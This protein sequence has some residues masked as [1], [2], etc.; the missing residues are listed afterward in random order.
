M[1]GAGSGGRALAALLIG[2]VMAGGVPA[3]AAAP[4][5]S[6]PEA[7]ST[8]SAPGVMAPTLSFTK[9]G[10]ISPAGI[11]L[12]VTWPRATQDGAPIA[13]YELERSLDGDAWT[14]VSLPKPKARSVAVKVRPWAVVRFRVRAVDTANEVGLWVES[15]PRWVS[16]AQEDDPAVALE[17]SWQS[18]ARNRAYGGR[19]ATSTYA[20]DTARYSFVGRQVA[21]VAGL[22]PNLGQAAVSA[23]GGSATSVD[24]YRSKASSRRIVYRQTWPEDGAHTLE[25]T[26][27]SPGAAVDVDAFLVLGDPGDATLVGAGDI[28]WC[29]SNGDSK[30]AAVIAGIEGIVYTAGDNAYPSGTPEEF[31]TC[32]DPTWGAF[33]DRTR[34][35]PGNHDYD[36]PGGAGYFEYFGANAGKPGE[37]WYWYEAGTWRVYALNSECADIGGCDVGSAQY[38]WL[39]ANL[40]AE[41]HRCVLSYWHYPLY[42][43]GQHGGSARM[44]AIF[45][46]L[47]NAGADLVL[48]AHDHTYERFAKARADGTADPVR[49][50]RQFVIGTGGAAL[51]AFETTHPLSEARDNSTHGVLRLDVSPGAYSWTFLPAGSGT[52]T[53]SGTTACH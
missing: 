33:K 30:T 32:Y 47:Y 29:T 42:S 21:W 27:T 7:R 23:D 10:R 25:V 6:R 36:T 22:G 37:G 40:A 49:G 20:G 34:P 12:T 26:T 1:N 3:A 5:P 17:G 53:D 16:V 41:P 31:A 43:S 14:A 51:Y 28:S 50:V 9:L 46:L 44:A 38:E 39:A 48:S 18:V 15:A 45:E 11:P 35:V 8:R 24:L 4:R 13:G 19:L 2:M 52:Y